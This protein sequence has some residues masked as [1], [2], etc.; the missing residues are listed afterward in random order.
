MGSPAAQRCLALA[1]R[2]A[3]P[4]RHAQMLH[5]TTPS[6]SFHRTLDQHRSA[7]TAVPATFT[8]ERNVEPG[9][10][11]I[12]NGLHHVARA[13][14]QLRK[15]AGPVAPCAMIG[16]ALHLFRTNK[17][18]MLVP[19]GAVCVAVVAAG[20]VFVVA[21]GVVVAAAAVVVV[22][23]VA[24]VCLFLLWLVLLLLWWLPVCSCGCC[25][26]WCCCSRV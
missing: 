20:A 9:N 4:I 24:P 1:R 5:R 3:P 17:G 22:V 18:V 16:K 23:V 26:C 25:S 21:V 10:S 7:N 13:T 14:E 15:V 19:V 12:C 11:V 6:C 2:I 8:K